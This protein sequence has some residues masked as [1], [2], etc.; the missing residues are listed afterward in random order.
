[1]R[2]IELFSGIGAFSQAV[3]SLGLP[4]EVVQA[5]DQ[6][7]SANLTYELNWGLKPRARNIESLKASSDLVQAELWW[8][9]PP[10]AP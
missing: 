9:S 2:A 10:C 7:D 5:Y 4:L 3:E 8:M 1:M 6:S